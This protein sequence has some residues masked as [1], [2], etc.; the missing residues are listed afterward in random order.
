MPPIH[1]RPPSLRARPLSAQQPTC[2][3]HLDI[4]QASHRANLG[5]DRAHG[6]TPYNLFCGL[7]QLIDRSLSPS[8]LQIKYLGGGGGVLD[9]SLS[10]ML[11]SSHQPS[12]CPGSWRSL[13]I[14]LRWCFWHYP[15]TLV[16]PVPTSAARVSTKVSATSLPHFHWILFHLHLKLLEG[17]YWTT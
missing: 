16:C 7:L 11:T 14:V 9:S 8:G 15:R 6:G 1:R 17:H 13:F 5:Q 4:P 10:F 2:P 12:P 3:P